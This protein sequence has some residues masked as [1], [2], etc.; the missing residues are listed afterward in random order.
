MGRHATAS[1]IRSRLGHPIIDVDGHTI[2]L[3]PVVLDY[4]ARFGGSDMATRYAKRPEMNKWYRMTE[5]E[6]LETRT[7]A[8][9]WWGQ[10]ATN[11]VDRA[12]A[13]LPGL[14]YERLEELGI[15]FA[16]MYPSDGL[17]IVSLPGI[18]DEETRRVCSRA[19]NTYQ[20]DMCGEFADR[21]TPAAVIPMETPQEAVDELEYA[22]KVLGYRVI[23][24]G[25]GVLRPRD[26][27]L[28]GQ[29][30]FERDAAWSDT[31]GLDSQFDYDPVWAKCLELGVALTSHGGTMG[32]GSRMSP[33]SYSYNHIGQFASAGEAI[34]KSLFMSGVA[35]RFPALNFAFLE[36]GVAWAC[37]VYADMLGHWEKR[38]GKAILDLD[39]GNL[40]VDLFMDLVHRYGGQGVRGHAES[41]RRRMTRRLAHPDVLDDWAACG[42]QKAEDI[43]DVFASQ[44]Y[45]GCEADDPL[46]GW[47]FDTAA[48]PLGARFRAMFGSDI[49]HWDVPDMREVVPEAYELVEAGRLTDEDF[50]DFAFGNAVRLHGQMNRDFFKGTAVEQEAGSVLERER[51]QVE[52]SA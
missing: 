7:S 3:A 44:F 17:T 21:L 25:S 26:A 40:D 13:V 10:P 43:R 38:N 1:E 14:L 41:V 27:A 19:F 8:R 37:R 20:M 49:G 50:H 45:Y 22:V 11:T 46:I 28:A 33:T 52:A 18:Q 15:D 31:F 32:T 16:I 23:A 47:A 12:T 6:R 4:I 24:T 35:H 36:G 29:F 48:N 2:E 42:I 39:P 34:T 5:G 51:S 30:D 9:P